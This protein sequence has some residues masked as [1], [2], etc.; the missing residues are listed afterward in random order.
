MLSRKYLSKY[1][2]LKVKRRLGD[3]NFPEEE[4]QYNQDSGP[5]VLSQPIIEPDDPGHDKKRERENLDIINGRLCESHNSPIIDN[6]PNYTSPFRYDYHVILPGTQ[7]SERTI[8]HEMEVVGR[9]GSLN[10]ITTHTCIDDLLSFYLDDSYDINN[11]GRYLNNDNTGI[12]NTVVIDWANIM[13]KHVREHLGLMPGDS[14]I[15]NRFVHG[16]II[17]D[18]FKDIIYH[19]SIVL[20]KF[21]IFVFKSNTA[22]TIDDCKHCIRDLID[23]IRND[24]RPIINNKPNMLSRIKNNFYLYNSEFINIHDNTMNC[25]GNQRI[26]SGIDDFAFWII[27]CSLVKYFI[28]LSPCQ[29]VAI[30][31]IID[32][33]TLFTY[34]TQNNHNA[35][36]S[37]SDNKDHLLRL[38]TPHNCSH[39]IS[40]LNV[41]ITDT[42]VNIIEE[43]SY[44]TERLYNSISEYLD[45]GSDSIKYSTV[46]YVNLKNIILRKT[47]S[48]LGFFRAPIILYEQLLRPEVTDSTSDNN[49]NLYLIFANR[50]DKNGGLDGDMNNSRQY[51][52]RNIVD[53]GI[54]FFQQVYRIQG[55][56]F[57]SDNNNLI[58]EKAQNMSLSVRDLIVT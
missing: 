57:G 50:Y 13:N 47:P 36:F 53:P 28:Y 34:D 42:E 1:N 24:E 32:H 35:R 48:A 26:T 15:L 16:N 49:V 31:R 56:L 20:N 44:H 39:R 18:L 25:R 41:G 22:F 4:E 46:N 12:R 5:M 54:A 19:Q 29:H 23:N 37:E 58:G 27:V 7:I 38:T 55:L 21:T 17:M 10:S 43:R 2:E 8:T 40:Y 11:I 6:F 51:S 33:I 45:N 30:N 14:L 3:D 9:V 52:D